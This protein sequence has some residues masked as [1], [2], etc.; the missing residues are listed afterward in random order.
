[1][2]SKNLGERGHLHERVETVYAVV[3]SGGLRLG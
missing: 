2:M 3:Y 1:M